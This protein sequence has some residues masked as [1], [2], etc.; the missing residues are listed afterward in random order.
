[1]GPRV[2]DHPLGIPIL[3]SMTVSFGFFERFWYIYLRTPNIFC[4]DRF[5]SI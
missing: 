3:L 5:A 4:L 2:E 1:M